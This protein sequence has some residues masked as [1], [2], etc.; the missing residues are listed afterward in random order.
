MLHVTTKKEKRSKLWIPVIVATCAMH[1]GFFYAGINWAES[2]PR[3]SYE[4]SRVEFRAIAPE[5]EPLPKPELEKIETPPPVKEPEIKVAKKSRPST[6]RPNTSKPEPKQESKEPPKPVFGATAD[7]VTN[8]ESGVAIR[9][10]NTLSKEMEKEFTKAKDV[11][12]L[13]PAPKGPVAPPQP[14]EKKKP[15]KPVPVY[16]LSRAPTFKNKV[17]P[18]YPDQ[19]RRDGI[20]G[21][22][23]LEILIDENGRV[24]K[25]KVLKSPGHGLDK[26]AIAAVSKSQ[27]HPGVINGKPVPVKIKIPYRF[28][29][30]A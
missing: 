20:E 21:T 28:V 1:V 2:K 29:L 19:A 13:P 23:Q 3:T 24:R 14:V 5:P 9:V 27:F 22:V 11:A 17:E 15:L 16:E 6:P 30:N 10:G 26:A 4:P 8:S 7:S 18:K 12:A 25:I